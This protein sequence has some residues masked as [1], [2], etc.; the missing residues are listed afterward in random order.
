[1]GRWPRLRFRLKVMMQESAE[2][3]GRP[4]L[5]LPQG[6][7]R[8]L[9]AFMVVLVIVVEV[10][11]NASI[12]VIWTE[13]LMIVLAHYFSSRRFI[14]LPPDVVRRLQEEGHLERDSHPLFLPRKG[15]A[16]MIVGTFLL[17]A[18]FLWS[19]G[20]L[21]NYESASILVTVFAYLIGILGRHAWD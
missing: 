1:M 18:I 12:E 19:Q 13:T 7:V 9:L 10:V 15:I 14:Q 2:I 20:R 3:P 21:F 8:A 16:A 6:S 5:G 11:R 4:P 17:L